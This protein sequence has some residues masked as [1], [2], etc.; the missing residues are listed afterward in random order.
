MFSL[1][2]GRMCMFKILFFSKMN[3]CLDYQEGHEKAEKYKH[4]CLVANDIV[5]NRLKKMYEIQTK[6]KELTVVQASK[7]V[8]DITELKKL[9]ELLLL[10]YNC[11]YHQNKY[12]RYYEQG[13]LRRK[14]EKCYSEEQLKLIEKNLENR[15]KGYQLR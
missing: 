9:K 11:G 15:E 13:K 1:L 8:D 4:L 12:Q 7:K 10:F 5:M 3:S 2:F 6:Q 14:L